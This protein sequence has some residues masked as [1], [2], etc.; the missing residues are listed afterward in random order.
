MS[1][2]TIMDPVTRIEGHMKVEVEIDQN[3]ITDARCTGTLFR[4]FETILEG[5]EPWDAPVI[6][7]RICG[8]CPISHGQAAVL[9][10][11]NAGGWT[12]PTNGRLLR[13]LT[14]GANFIQSHILHFYLLAALDYI[15]GPQVTPWIPGWDVDMRGG[16]EGIVDNLTGPA[17]V[18]RRRAHEMGAVFG[19]KMPAS[20]T[21]IPGGFTATPTAERIALFREHLDFLTDFIVNIYLND[22]EKLAGVYEQYFNI[23]AG[24]NNLLSYGVFELDNSGQQKLLDRGYV[25]DRGTSPQ[26]VISDKDITESV[27]YSWYEDTTNNLTPINGETEPIYPKGDAYSWLKAPRLSGRPFE[28]GPLARMWV[29]GDYQDGISV[30]D[31]HLARALETL[32]IAEE[33]SFWLDEL[34]PGDPVAINAPSPESGLGVGMT[35]APRGALGHWT[36]L[37]QGKIRHYQIITPTCWNASPL[38]DKDVHGPMEQALI[39]IPIQ[40]PSRPIEALRVIHSFDPCLSCA[41]HVI[42]PEG[43]P[44]VLKAGVK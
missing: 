15:Q 22:V 19:G 5:R 36:L 2:I 35:E 20:H 30:M 28:V 43:T 4:G 11:D 12:P 39:G 27:T 44:L 42:T 16:L 18:A 34:R 10:L 14:L 40:D 26:G 23:G 41:V 7:Q 8:V 33:M 31:R 13:N 9:A 21:F 29:N 17:L 1:T 32:K 37:S 25:V 38:D 24:C 6:T 3:K